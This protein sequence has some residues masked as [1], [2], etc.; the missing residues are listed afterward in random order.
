LEGL[1]SFN[2]YFSNSRSCKKLNVVFD[3]GI[4]SGK[5]ERLRGKLSQVTDL[6]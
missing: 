3:T 6:L 2:H 1:T 5:F 4:L